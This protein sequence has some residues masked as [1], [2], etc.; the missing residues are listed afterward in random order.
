M[1]ETSNSENAINATSGGGVDPQPQQAEP[2]E[3]ECVSCGWNTRREE[4][5]VHSDTDDLLCDDCYRDRCYRDRF[6]RDCYGCNNNYHTD[7]LDGDGYCVYC[8]HDEEGD[9]DSSD[10]EI[11]ET[12][13]DTPNSDKTELTSERTFGIEFEM[14]GGKIRTIKGVV[15]KL[16]FSYS[17]DGSID[18]E[19]GIEVQTSVLKKGDEEK[20]REFT[21]AAQKA[22]FRVN[23]SCGT[24]IH[25]GGEGFI[26][27]NRFELTNL[28][29]L[30]GN[31]VVV[32]AVLYKNMVSSLGESGAYDKLFTEIPY[33]KTND[34][35]N[36]LYSGI[37]RMENNKLSRFVVVPIIYRYNTY[38]FVIRNSTLEKIGLDLSEIQD[39][40]IKLFITSR[41]NSPEENS[42]YRAFDIKQ[43][44]FFARKNTESDYALKRLLS[45]YHYYDDLFMAMLRKDRATNTYCKSLKETYSKVDIDRV[46]NQGDIEKLWYK[47]SDFGTVAMAKQEHYNSSRYHS[48]NLHSLF[49]KF[50]TVEIR[51]HHPTLNAES[52]LLWVKLHQHILD[53]IVA[54]AGYF[55]AYET[56]D[57]RNW[58]KYIVTLFKDFT[59]EF[60]IKEDSDLYR[61]IVHR[62]KKYSDVVLSDKKVV[63]KKIS[64]DNL[65]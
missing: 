3:Y 10:Y 61:F 53:R 43:C 19:N 8:E 36:S 65:F 48:V 40:D 57:K 11:V 47:C 20:V 28:R 32:E 12:G 63:A 46:N 39:K 24:H 17:G 59:R 60:A 2:Q 23:T 56:R 29:S 54:K 42:V 55:G 64:N 51:S 18:G 58:K 45:V 41:G 4:D 22:D 31:V 15:E 30:N 25:L 62:L 14:F 27:N 49:T 16:G 5:L 9:E 35:V 6:Y 38:N 1:P 34:R 26:N 33:L 21:Q 37:Y 44:L 50:G 13:D 7:D 52:I